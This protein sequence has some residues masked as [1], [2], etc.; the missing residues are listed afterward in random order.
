[1]G[2]QI[3]DAT[4]VPALKQRGHSGEKRGDKDGR[5]PG[6]WKDKPATLG[7]KDRDA[8]ASSKYA[9]ADQPLLPAKAPASVEI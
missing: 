8:R 6:R 2:G 4:M 3:I 7:Q 1:M 5:I 9:N